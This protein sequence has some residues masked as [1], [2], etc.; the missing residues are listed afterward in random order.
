[1]CVDIVSVG[2]WFNSK[3]PYSDPVFRPNIQTPYSDPVFRPRIQ[4][5][6]SDQPV[7]VDVVD[8]V[9]SKNTT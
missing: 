4:T 6:Y 8:H 7:D 3:T 1:M 9:D 2:M 5:P